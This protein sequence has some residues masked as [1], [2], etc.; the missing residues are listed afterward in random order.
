MPDRR[1]DSTADAIR[2][3]MGDRRIDIFYSDRSGEIERALRDLHIVSDTSQPRVPQ[4]NAVA[5]RL[6]Q[7]ILEGTRTAL[8][9]AGLPPCFWEYAC[10]HYCLMENVLPGR[11]SAAAG[12]DKKSPWEKMHGEPFYG[13]LIPIGA[14][15]FIKPSE[16]KGDSTSKMEHWRLRRIRAIFWMPLERY[17][18]G[19]VSRRI[20]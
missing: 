13:K 1:A 11:E 3:F 6:V 9:R 4:N 12:V 20:H 2:H 10:Q 14:K 18:H 8:L 5:E 19:L 15:V 16:T 7:D 17:L